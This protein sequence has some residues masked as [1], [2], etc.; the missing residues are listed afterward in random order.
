MQHQAW[1][2]HNWA[3]NYAYRAARLHRPE[4]VHELRALV[5][6]CDHVKVL[7]TRHSFND[8][9]DTAGDQISLER[10][11][12]ITSIDPNPLH[13]T[14]TLEAGV[15]YGQLAGH[16]HD[17]GY[18]LPNLA[19][20]PHISVA[21]ACATGTHGS[22]DRNGNLATGVAAME[23]VTAD[24]GVR[25]LSREADGE[26]FRGAVVSL[27][28][29]GVVTTLTLDII[30]TFDV[31]QTVYENLTLA[32]L[33]RHFD[34]ITACAHSVSLFTDWQ[35]PRFTQVWLKRRVG[36]RPPDAAGAA[37]F[38][39]TPAKRDMHPIAG[40]SAKNCT[41]Q[42]GAPGPWHERLP[43]FRME[44]TPSS[45]EELQ[46]EYFV[47]RGHAVAALC[48]IDGLRERIAPLLQV[49]EVRTMAA[50]ALW[51]SPCYRRASAAIHFTWKKDSPAVSA[52]LPRIETALSPFD[53]RPHWG[54]LFTMPPAE[55]RS[56]YE[57]LADFRKLLRTFDSG[58]KFRNTFLDRYV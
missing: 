12:R 31:Q 17:A 42:M 32:A 9:A 47:P 58:G 16:L 41:A 46:S 52:L 5:A 34:E 40:I 30:P 8:V 4:T 51:M 45:G 56:R 25:A 37:L 48:A 10:L 49:S 26:L 13:P 53:A 7:G 23:I 14:V 20:L 36:D 24:G 19:S 33:T 1:P 6:R 38:G 44:F 22:G 18:A 11:C 55:L 50:D 28:G 35:S 27:G 54:K 39:A 3:G 43:H 15:T 21:G 57:K 29:L 2:R